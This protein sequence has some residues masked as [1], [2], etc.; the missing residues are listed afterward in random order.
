MHN[1]QQKQWWERFIVSEERITTKYLL[2]SVWRKN[3][4][5]V[6]KKKKILDVL[7]PFVGFPFDREYCKKYIKH[8]EILTRCKERL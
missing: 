6:K 3:D 1:S 5:I 4:V 7:F 8:I 2:I